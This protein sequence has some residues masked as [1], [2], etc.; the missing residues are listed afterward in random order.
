MYV[1]LCVYL[2]YIQCNMHASSLFYLIFGSIFRCS[3]LIMDFSF[4]LSLCFTPLWA[5]MHYRPMFFPIEFHDSLNLFSERLKSLIH[6]LNDE[7]ET[8]NK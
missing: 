1:C 6:L 4:S 8:I 7:A 2:A 3:A 5:I